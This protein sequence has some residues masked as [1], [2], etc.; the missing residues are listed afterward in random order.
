MRWLPFGCLAVALALSLYQISRDIVCDRSSLLIEIWFYGSPLLLFAA[1]ILI[2]AATID[3]RMQGG[4]RG[5][6]VAWMLIAW[7]GVASVWAVSYYR[8]FGCMS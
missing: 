3:Q 6:W 1:L 2:P 8:Q 7:F 4:R 5:I